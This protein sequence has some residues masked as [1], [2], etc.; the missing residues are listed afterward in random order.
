M[1]LNGSNVTEHRGRTKRT[2]I[3]PAEHANSSSQFL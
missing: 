1:A 3:A 2:A